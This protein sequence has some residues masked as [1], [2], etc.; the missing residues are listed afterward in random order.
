MQYFGALRN[1]GCGFCPRFLNPLNRDIPYV[2]SGG[3]IVSVG[4][5]GTKIEFSVSFPQAYAKAPLVS[6]LNGNGDY[7]NGRF[8]GIKA[9]SL[10]KTGFTG[11]IVSTVASN[12][13]VE[14]MAIGI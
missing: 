2:Q 14:W 8:I 10:S 13:Q 4:Q 7:A 11:F 5:T 3:T 12:V 9:G 1:V 6:I